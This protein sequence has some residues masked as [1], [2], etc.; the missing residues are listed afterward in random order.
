MSVSVETG[1]KRSV[2]FSINLTPFLDF[3][4]VLISFLLVSAVWT[5]LARLDVSPQTPGA[6]AAPGEPHTP[7][8]LFLLP[9]G[10][11]LVTGPIESSEI[12]KRGSEYDYAALYAR[13]TALKHE[14]PERT[15]LTVEAGNGI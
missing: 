7:R 3:L 8:Q 5:Q 12:P 15:D 2:S 4:S 10:F 6:S 11:R 13:L 1:G 14:D 9:E